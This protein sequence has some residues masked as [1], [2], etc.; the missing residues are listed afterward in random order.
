MLPTV[1]L[2]NVRDV[3][4]KIKFTTGATAVPESTNC[5]EPEGYVTV[6]D[7]VLA[8]ADDGANFTLTL[9]LLLAGR[10]AGQ[11][12]VCVKSAD[13]VMLFSASEADPLFVS[14]ANWP[15]ELLPTF[16]LANVSDVGEKDNPT[17]D[18]TA[19]PE[20]ISCCEPEG[21]ATVTDP[22]FAPVVDGANLTVTLQLPF[23]GSAAGQLFVCTK[24]VVAVMLLSVKGADPLF[25]ST[26]G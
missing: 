7:P 21:Y 1:V 14:T 23:A 25:V 10:V 26:A 18:A 20:S 15:G 5:C 6:T 12:F 11:S 3:G 8:P 9:Q 16:A 19:V 22:V 13:A 17:T 24:S 4:A 2:A